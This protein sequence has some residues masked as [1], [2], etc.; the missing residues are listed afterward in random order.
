MENENKRPEMVLRVSDLKVVVWNNEVKV[1]DLLE[2]RKS[3][4]IEKIYKVEDDWKTTKSFN[5][6]DID[7]IIYLLNNFKLKVFPINVNNNKE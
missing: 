7:K 5:L 2:N 6:S 4:T 1:N 3:F